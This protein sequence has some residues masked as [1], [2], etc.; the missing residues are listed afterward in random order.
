MKRLMIRLFVGALALTLNA[1]VFAAGKPVG[2]V[3]M[4]VGKVSAKSAE[5]V[6][7]L[8]RQSQI[9]EGDT[10]LTAANAQGQVRMVDGALIA[11][12][13]GAEFHIKTYRFRQP[14][15][16]DEVA[17]ALAKG[18]LRTVT[19]QAEKSGYTMSY[20]TGTLGVRG[21]VYEMIVK[22]DGTAT[23]VLREGAVGVTPVSG[24]VVSGD[25]IIVDTPGEGVTVTDVVSDPTVLSD[26]ALVAA[27]AAVLP[28]PQIMADGTVVYTFEI[29]TE[30]PP[31]SP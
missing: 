20:P 24:G 6:R 4:T 21:T 9:F 8:K 19:G 7:D 13:S 14:G 31:A 10:L 28:M 27:L 16:K 18:A 15:Q 29:P 26:P 5:G 30:L 2:Q 22:A 11:L 3:L 17:L 25:T 12:G 23:I 1:A